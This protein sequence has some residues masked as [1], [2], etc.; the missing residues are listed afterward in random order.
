MAAK[1]ET[2]RKGKKKPHR[3]LSRLRKPED[4]SLEDWQIGLRREFAQLQKFR[5]KNLGRRA[6]LLRV[7]G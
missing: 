3:A 2:K 1:S 4:M 7:R 6:G 5:V